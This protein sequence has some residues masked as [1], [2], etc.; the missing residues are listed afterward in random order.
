MRQRKT[1]FRSWHHVLRSLPTL[2][3]LL[4]AAA[5]AQESTA[6][7]ASGATPATSTAPSADPAAYGVIDRRG[8]VG[9]SVFVANMVSDFDGFKKF[10]EDGAEE[11]AK[12]GV[13]GH[14]LTRLSDGRVVIHLFASD[15]DALKM[16]LASPALQKYLDRPG[17]PAFAENTVPLKCGQRVLSRRIDRR[18][19]T[20][21]LTQC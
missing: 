8:K 16:T 3:A 1:H 12:A 19:P 15:L 5:C 6:P 4:C 9:A 10:F 17:S 20:R 18:P 14:L 11:R 13:K 7:P 21:I 2:P